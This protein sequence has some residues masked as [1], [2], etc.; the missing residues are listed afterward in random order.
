[1]SELVLR[2]D[3]VLDLRAAA[4]WYE[5]QQPGLGDRFTTQLA[6]TFDGIRAFPTRFRCIDGAV[7]RALVRQFP[8]SVGFIVEPSRVVVLGVFHQHRDPT[9]WRER[10]PDDPG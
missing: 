10:L 7:R 2:P 6:A 3:A 8:Y 4:R 1:M 9:V 5:E